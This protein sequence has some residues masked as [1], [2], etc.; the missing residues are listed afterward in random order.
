MPMINNADI[1]QGYITDHHIIETE[2]ILSDFKKQAGFLTFN[3]S[4]L[5][6]KT[7]VQKIKEVILDL[8]MELAATPN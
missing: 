1:K 2:L 7:Y 3:N 8:K 4:L 5:G 6:D